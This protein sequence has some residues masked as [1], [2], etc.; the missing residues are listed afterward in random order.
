MNLSLVQNEL[1]AA[2]PLGSQQPLCLRDPL[3]VDKLAVKEIVAS[4]SRAQLNFQSAVTPQPDC[5][6]SD[7]RS[8]ML[9]HKKVVAGAVI[10]VQVMVLR[11]G[12]S[13]SNTEVFAV[14]VAK[15][16]AAFL[17]CVPHSSVRDAHLLLPPTC[18]L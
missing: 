17:H 6:R 16:Q 9:V 15:W 12:S 5:Q 2:T 4:R 8:M 11:G 13:C 10:V 14:V 3:A 18:R 7:V 1:M